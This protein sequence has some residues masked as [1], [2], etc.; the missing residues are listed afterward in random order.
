M[1]H[2]YKKILTPIR[3]GDVVIRTRM[4]M[5]K[6]NSQEQQGPENFP[7]EGTAS[8]RML[9]KTVRPSSPCPPPR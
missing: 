1:N 2:R 6:C 3:V 7:A 8:L 4:G 9:P 5:S